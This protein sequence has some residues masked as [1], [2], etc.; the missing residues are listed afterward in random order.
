MD[1]IQ[2]RWLEGNPPTY[3]E[4][5]DM[6][7][8]EYRRRKEEGVQPKHEW[9]YINLAQKFMKEHPNTS[10]KDFLKEWDQTRKKNLTIAHEILERVFKKQSLSPQS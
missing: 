8:K 5:A 2:E 3:Q 10:K 1:W 6:W 4:F 9:A 7:I